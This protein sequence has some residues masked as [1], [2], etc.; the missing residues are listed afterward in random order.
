M[1]KKTSRI[2]LAP[3]LFENINNARS[4]NDSTILALHV[5]VVNLC[6]QLSQE[7]EAV[8]LIARPSDGLFITNLGKIEV[9]FH[10][11][12]G[13]LLVHAGAESLFPLDCTSYKSLSDRRN[14]SWPFMWRVTSTGFL[15]D[16]K[17]II[18]NIPLVKLSKSE[19]RSR[20]IPSWVK[21]FVHL[22]DKGR[23]VHCNSN[24]N[25]H[26]DHVI[27]FSM[28]GSND[29]ENI[30]ILCSTHNLEKSASFR[31]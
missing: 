19:R 13:H 10:F 27:P 29:K 6:L 1:A 8:G 23:C 12:K 25:I 2:G 24:E 11:R 31:Y 28:G 14:G 26:F 20:N 21:E 16:L 5:G 30:Q 22:R 18:S 4:D 9:Y 7:N 3:A 15:K 17:V